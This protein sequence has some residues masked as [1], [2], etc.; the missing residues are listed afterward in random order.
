MWLFA[1]LDAWRTAH[2]IRSGMTPD[3]AEDILVRRFSGNP[4]MWGIVLLVLGG[5]FML[6]SVLNLRFLMRGLVPAMLIGLGIY[7][8]RGYI[9]KPKEAATG[10]E[11]RWKPEFAIS[12]SSYSSRASYD[13]DAAYSDRARSGTWRER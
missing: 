11:P 12:D 3:I 6:Q 2:M 1:A 5:A 10:P 4:K 13:P 9:F 8:L 7:L